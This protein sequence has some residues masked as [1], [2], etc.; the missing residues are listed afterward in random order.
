MAK[1]NKSFF[2]I[3]FATMTALILLAFSVSTAF[4]AGS[5][6]GTV[7][8]TDVNVSYNSNAVYFSFATPM[9][10]G[11]TCATLKTALAF[12]STSLKGKTYLAL[13]TAAFLAGKP[14]RVSGAGICT[15]GEPTIEN[16]AWLQVQP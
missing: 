15:S 13:V 16:V 6:A 5:H 7:I 4:A 14:V 11:P 10:G 9:T 12:D 8:I 3:T 2:G 1:L